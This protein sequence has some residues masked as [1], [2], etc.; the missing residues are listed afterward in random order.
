MEAEGTEPAPSASSALC[1][2]K[3][4]TRAAPSLSCGELSVLVSVGEVPAHV[5]VSALEVFITAQDLLLMHPDNCCVKRKYVD[6]QSV[7]KQ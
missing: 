1:S 5:L 4:M 2:P 3:L 6:D 7:S